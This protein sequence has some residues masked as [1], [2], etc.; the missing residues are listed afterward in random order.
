[1][2][3]LIE[4]VVALVQRDDGFVPVLSCPST[5]VSNLA[6]NR[7]SCGAG[8][9]RHADGR[10]YRYSNWYWWGRWV[11]AGVAILFSLIVL[12][13]LLYVTY[14]HTSTY[15]VCPTQLTRLDSQP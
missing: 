8:W 5:S 10:C 2:A 6:D 1:M 7:F 3:P 9:S 12:G 11:L 13:F 15:A 14:F 4:Q